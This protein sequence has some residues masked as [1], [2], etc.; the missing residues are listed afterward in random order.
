MTIPEEGRHGVVIDMRDAAAALP[1]A[2]KS[3]VISRIGGAGVKVLRMDGAYHEE[4]HDYP[5]A[6]LV[7][8]GILKLTIDGRTI[9]V[10]EG[11]MFVV[12]PGVA[13]G[14]AAGSSGTLI[15]VDA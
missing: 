13:H 1:G 8:D 5:E 11:E 10:G 7:I 2:W 15:I 3:T 6:L 12:P 9:D 4:K 14:V